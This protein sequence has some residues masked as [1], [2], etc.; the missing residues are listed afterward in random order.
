MTRQQAEAAVIGAIVEIQEMSG[1]ECLNIGANTKPIGDVPEF[2][3]LNAFEATVE[4]AARLRME[5][6][7]E[8]NIFIN[9]AGDRVLSVREIAGRLME[10]AENS[11]GVAHGKRG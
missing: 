3:S 8:A 4:V 9:E 11:E 5:I 2:D 1:R 6:P 7:N 10:I